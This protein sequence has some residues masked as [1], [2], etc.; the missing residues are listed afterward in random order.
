[1]RA[2]PRRVIMPVRSTRFRALS[3]EFR[4][5][6]DQRRGWPLVKRFPRALED[7]GGG[8]K[9]VIF[10][11]KTGG[12]VPEKFVRATVELL[13][14]ERVLRDFLALGGVTDHGR[15][16][17]DQVMDLIAGPVMSHATPAPGADDWF[18][19]GLDGLVRLFTDYAWGKLVREGTLCRNEDDVQTAVTMI[20]TTAGH[21]ISGRGPDLPAES[22]IEIAERY[23]GLTRDAY[24]TSVLESWRAA[25]W[26][27]AFAVVDRRRV[28]CSHVLPL[29]ESAY[30]EVRA[31]KRSVYACPAADFA[32][33]SRFLFIEAVGDMPETKYAL[34]GRRTAQQLR[35]I[36]LQ[37]AILSRDDAAGPPG[38]QRKLR[39]LC[40]EGPPTDRKRAMRFGF[41]PTGTRMHIVNKEL[42]EIDE[43]KSWFLPLVVQ[44]LQKRLAETGYQ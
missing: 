32:Q 1:L 8:R 5:F 42:I 28:G 23:I 35:T 17:V 12:V 2:A 37:M 7:K 13:W 31:G 33:P 22:A 43:R 3:D 21:H 27:L 6:L 15:L 19:K 30:E 4:D 20:L 18:M 29:T 14:N 25:P 41:R 26:S 44:Y 16:N 10:Q 34:I 38:Q 39:L 36:F 9:A 40:I 11:M 24:L